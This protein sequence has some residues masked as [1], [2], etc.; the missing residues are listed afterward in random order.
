MLQKFNRFADGPLCPFLFDLFRHI[1]LPKVTG[2]EH[3]SRLEHVVDSSQYHPSDGDDGSFLPPTARD[4]FILDFV[5]GLAGAF[6][7]CMSN[8]DEHWFDVDSGAGNPDGFFLASRLVVARR[9]SSP[10]A[11][12]LRGVELR[13]IRANFGDDRNG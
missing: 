13:H 9:Q 1:N 12:S 5:V 7:G 4:V 3:F 11:K 2:V 8:L 10:A 6:Y